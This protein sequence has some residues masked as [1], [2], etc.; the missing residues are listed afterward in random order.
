MP[1][2]SSE[3]VDDLEGVLQDAH[4]HQLLAVVAAVHHERVGEALH[5]RALSL[6]EPL[7]LVTAR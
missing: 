3:Q 6:A 7:H 1:Y 5:D 4:C 2:L